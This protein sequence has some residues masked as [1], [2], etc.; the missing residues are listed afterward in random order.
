MKKVTVYWTECL[1]YSNTF[2][3][4][5]DATEQA[6]I[7]PD[8]PQEWYDGGEVI[9]SEVETDSIEVVFD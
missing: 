1:H 7:G 5:D 3:V 2:M 8:S 6:I 9:E 4:P